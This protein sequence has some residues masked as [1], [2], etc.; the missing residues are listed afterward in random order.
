MASTRARRGISKLRRLYI[1]EVNDRLWYCFATC[2]SDIRLG[3]MVQGVVFNKVTAYLI[4]GYA[5]TVPRNQNG[6]HKQLS[7]FL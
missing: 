2:M 6:P 7:L 1:W 4:G 5:R 3:Q